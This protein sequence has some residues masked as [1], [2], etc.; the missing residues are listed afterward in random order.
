M[1]ALF[2]VRWEHVACVWC[3]DVPRRVRVGIKLVM[4]RFGVAGN[5]TRKISSR[6][7]PSSASSRELGFGG[8]RGGAVHVFHPDVVQ[9]GIIS[10]TRGGHVGGEMDSADVSRQNGIRNLAFW[11]AIAANS[12]SVI[13]P[14]STVRSSSVLLCSAPYR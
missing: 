14:P 6:R 12:K 11:L 10:D 7:H 1:R 4:E 13:S 9:T 3:W 2:K 5:E 8:N